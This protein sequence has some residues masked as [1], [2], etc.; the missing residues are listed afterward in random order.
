M[1]CQD[2]T[3]ALTFMP[4]SGKLRQNHTIQMKANPMNAARQRQEEISAELDSLHDVI[5]EKLVRL[6]ALRAE[7]AAADKDQ[8]KD[9]LSGR[10]TT[11]EA[12]FKADR[13]TYKALQKEYA[14]LQSE[15]IKLA[16][17]ELQE[18]NEACIEL[19][20]RPWIQ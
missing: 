19:T 6:K 8:G 14:D 18:L 16:P 15:A 2:E 5:G 4:S 3:T 9:I 1:Y 7:T 13:E 10:L 20:G 12:D 17:E 11:A